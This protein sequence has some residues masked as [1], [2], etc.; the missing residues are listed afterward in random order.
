VRK[1]KAFF[2]GKG[3]KTSGGMM[4]YVGRPG[5]GLTGFCFT[6]PDDCERFRKLVAFAAGL[7]DELIFDDLFIF[8]CRCE[9]CQKAKGDPGAGRNT[10][11]R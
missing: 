6:N 3:I 7:F 10:V 4:A 11:C 2:T 1:V 8:D 5:D 9:L